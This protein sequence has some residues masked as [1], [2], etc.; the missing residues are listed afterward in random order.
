MR[1]TFKLEIKVIGAT[2]RIQIPKQAL[3]VYSFMMHITEYM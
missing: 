1:Q 3:N 2:E